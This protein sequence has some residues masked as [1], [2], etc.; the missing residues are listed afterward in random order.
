MIVPGVDRVCQNL[1][2]RTGAF[3][4]RVIECSLEA[5]VVVYIFAQHI[6][7]CSCCIASQSL[8][9][10]K[11][12]DSFTACLGVFGEFEEELLEAVDQQDVDTLTL[13]NLHKLV[14]HRLLESV[15]AATSEDIIH[16]TK[17]S[18]FKCKLRLLG[19]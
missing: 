4:F 1:N 13:E 16:E 17:H 12:V 18:T 7:S 5:D 10:A 6:A 11:F 14:L 8:L 3:T 15:G 19:T 2:S 9:H